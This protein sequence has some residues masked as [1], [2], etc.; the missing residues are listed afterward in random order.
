MN[1]YVIF[2]ITGEFKKSEND[3]FRLGRGF[4]CLSL[5]RHNPR[6]AWMI[7]VIHISFF[8][9]LKSLLCKSNLYFVC[10]FKSLSQVKISFFTL[11][12]LL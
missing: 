7:A 2:C 10:S 6:M 12:F 9:I 11:V 4:P 1:C 5:N 3:N 8:S